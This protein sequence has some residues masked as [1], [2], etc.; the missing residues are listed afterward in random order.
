MARTKLIAIIGGEGANDEIRTEAG[1][2]TLVE[3]TARR[4]DE[5]G[6]ETTIHWPAKD[7]KDFP[8]PG[9]FDAIVI[10]GSKLNIR[11]EDLERFTWMRRLLDFIK[12]NHGKVPMLGICFGHQAIARSFGVKVKQFGPDMVYEA[13]F[14][15]VHLTDEGR[16]DAL[17]AGMPDEFDALFSHFYYVPEPPE[18]GIVLLTGKNPG[19][20]AFRLGER[21]WGVQ[22]HPEISVPTVRN[23]VEERRKMLEAKGVDVDRILATLSS[24]PRRDHLVLANF[25][26]IVKKS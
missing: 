13:G 8:E 2:S 26:E 17:F 10:G 21:T 11:D 18:G 23:G 9:T 19:T 1:K 24:G 16:K 4:F 25:A 6:M 15:S 7:I 3:E 12:E 14:S 5:L 22:Y 20:Y